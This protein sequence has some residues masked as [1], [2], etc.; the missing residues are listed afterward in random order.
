MKAKNLVVAVDIDGYIAERTKE[1]SYDFSDFTPIPR[2]IEKVNNLFRKGYV[3]IY[4][5]ARHQRYYESTY[6]WL[7]RYGCEF[8]ALRMGKMHAHY[9]LD[10]RNATME[11]LINI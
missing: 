5:T 11:E 9:Y 4:Y 6:A 1:K 10:D 3:V 8:H 2:V 7:I